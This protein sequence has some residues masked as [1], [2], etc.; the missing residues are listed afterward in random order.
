MARVSVILP[1][2]NESGN[3][4]ELVQRVLQATREINEAEVV[5][6]DD[7]SPDG[8]AGLVRNTF[9]NEPRVRLHV[10]VGERGLASAIRKGIELSSGQTI[11]VMD[12]DFNHDPRYI[13]QFLKLIQYYDVV[14]GSRFLYGGGM[15]SRWRYYASLLYNIFIR[16]ALGIPIS[17]K[18]SGFFAVRREALRKLDFD[19]IFYGYGDYF[20][21][22]LMTMVDLKLSILEI[23]VYYDNRPA[24]ESKTMFLKE[25]F[26]YTKS[27]I[28]I[29]FSGK[30]SRMNGK[31]KP[32]AVSAAA[33]K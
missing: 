25:F 1:T 2:Y 22:F 33:K 31:S 29:R 32:E 21:R 27:V 7:S 19:H 30:N 11:I 24:G 28:Q 8:T 26:R 9:V 23:P 14:V 12:T 4:I 10:R 15:Y 3:I 13:P 17:D 20:I 18:L 6:V 5:V 16:F